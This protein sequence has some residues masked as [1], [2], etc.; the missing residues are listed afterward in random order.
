MLNK[1]MFLNGENKKEKFFYLYYLWSFVFLSYFKIL[2]CGLTVFPESI[3]QNDEIYT[4]SN[5]AGTIDQI[6][7]AGY[8]TKDDSSPS[9]YY[10]KKNGITYDK[11]ST[12]TGT[13]SS[14]LPFINPNN[15]PNGENS[16][17]ENISNEYGL[18]KYSFGSSGYFQCDAPFPK[19][20]NQYYK[21]S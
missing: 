10:S 4:Y 19:I 20:M 17:K 7:K 5:K 11:D 1:L 16:D 15:F 12:C 3:C 2:K 18:F 6:Y 9:T 13:S 8:Y 21:L 14:S